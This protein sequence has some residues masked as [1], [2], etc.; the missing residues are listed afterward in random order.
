MNLE[1]FGIR[2]RPASTVMLKVS[3]KRFRPVGIFR[4]PT[5]ACF[6]VIDPSLNIAVIAKTE[7]TLHLKTCKK[8]LVMMGLYVLYCGV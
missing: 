1:N 6:D 7:F 8:K 3:G 4:I 2:F 5:E